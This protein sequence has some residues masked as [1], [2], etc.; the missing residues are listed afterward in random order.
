[1]DD[2]SSLVRDWFIVL[3][4]SL[5]TGDPAWWVVSKQERGCNLAMDIFMIVGDCEANAGIAVGIAIGIAHELF[6]VAEE[7]GHDGRRSRILYDPTRRNPIQVN[8]DLV[9]AAIKH[10]RDA[11]GNK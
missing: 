3:R 11:K 10:C 1:M 5:R 8:A 7:A 4:L 2:D 9:L 6:C